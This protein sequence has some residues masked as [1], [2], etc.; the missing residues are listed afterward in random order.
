MIEDVG[1]S[2]KG[3]AVV[4]S[5]GYAPRNHMSPTRSCGKL[6]LEP[7]VTKEPDEPICC[8]KYT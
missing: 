1:N 6:V 7:S 8:L 3:Y 2:F 5:H 4:L